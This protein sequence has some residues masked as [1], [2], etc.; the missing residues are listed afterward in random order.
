MLGLISRMKKKSHEEKDPRK[1]E[2]AFQALKQSFMKIAVSSE[3]TEKYIREDEW[4]QEVIFLGKP[5]E[6]P[7]N[8]FFQEFEGR[9]TPP[10]LDTFN[11]VKVLGKG[12]QAKVVSV[13]SKLTHHPYALKIISKKLLLRQNMVAQLLK[14]IAILSELKHES[15]IRF[16]QA[17]EDEANIYM[18]LE[19][20][21]EDH[22]Y[23]RLKNKGKYK[24]KDALKV[25]FHVLKAVNYLHTHPLKIIHRDIK[26]ENILF[27][28][29]GRAKLSDF[30]CSTTMAL[31]RETFCGTRD[32]LSPEMITKKKVDR[33]LDVWTLGILFYELCSKR[34][35]FSPDIAVMASKEE[36]NRSLYDNIL[37]KKVRFYKSMSE[38]FRDL[39]RRMLRKD[40]KERITCQEALQHEL[41][42]NN[43]LVYNKDKEDLIRKMM[44]ENHLEK[45]QKRKKRVK[46]EVSP[47]REYKKSQNPL[48]R[49]SESS[50][51]SYRMVEE[52]HSGLGG[53][54]NKAGSAYKNGKKEGHKKTKSNLLDIPGPLGMMSSI[55]SKNN[56]NQLCSSVKL[57]TDNEEDDAIDIGSNKSFLSSNASPQKAR[58]PPQEDKDSNFGYS[59]KKQKKAS[60]HEECDTRVGQS[61]SNRRI[62]HPHQHQYTKSVV[63]DEEI[64]SMTVK[65]LS[66]IDPMRALRELRI[67][68]KRVKKDNE[69]FRTILQLKNIMIQDLEVELANIKTKSL[70]DKDGGLMT[71]EGLNKLY[72]NLEKLKRNG[73]TPVK[74]KINL[75]QDKSN[76]S[77]LR[78]TIASG[79]TKS[80]SQ[81]SEEMQKSIELLMLQSEEL[82]AQNC[83][84]SKQVYALEHQNEL[85]EKENIRLKSD[86]KKLAHLV[87][88]N[89]KEKVAVAEEKDSHIEA[90]ERKITTI[91]KE[92]ENLRISVKGALDPSEILEVGS[93]EAEIVDNFARL[94]QDFK[95]LKCLENIE[96]RKVMTE[97]KKRERRIRALEEEISLLK[98][99]VNGANG[100]HK[101]AESAENGLNG[102]EASRE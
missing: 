18:V 75:E 10:T 64:R 51:K 92:L 48:S 53:H 12:A 33:K 91:F 96:R 98:G 11:W 58:F 35:P 100:V 60:I 69:E 73:G 29:N 20:G 31:S 81:T 76:T 38:G 82:Q 83:E 3:E 39:L 7:L 21:Q 87:I 22:L 4:L 66:A 101:E 47:P 6:I 15:I 30:G 90:L 88:K 52:A 44:K 80:T 46:I 34:T 74:K 79:G 72:S 70:K 63:T 62:K 27:G 1:I 84:I 43:G 65:Q 61:Q 93:S 2:A 71:Q 99:G 67:K 89:K 77:S 19:R 57:D 16:Y 78:T 94:S 32:Y 36:V 97:F 24:E 8:A 49:A 55:L 102:V 26:P 42:I 14:T 56:N 5:H 85:L 45:T 50:P 23:T 13:T 28:A 9:D 17:F 59:P 54:S 86:A 68:Y 25:M 95:H 40:R 37:K 41:F